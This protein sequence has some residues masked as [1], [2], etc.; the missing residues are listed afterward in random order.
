MREAETGRTALY[1]VGVLEATLN[2]LCV[3]WSNPF[4]THNDGAISR[5][6]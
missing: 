4:S 5:A 3:R 1:F 6:H 2:S